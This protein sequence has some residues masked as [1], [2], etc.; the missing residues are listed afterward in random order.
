M[1]EYISSGHRIYNIYNVH[2]CS[3]MHE[4]THY[5]WRPDRALR[6]TMAEEQ[7]VKKNK[8]NEHT[9]IHMYICTYIWC[10]V[11]PPQEKGVGAGQG[12]VCVFLL[13]ILFER[14]EFLIDTS[15]K[16]SLH[17]CTRARV[18]ACS[19]SLGLS[20]WYYVPYT[21]V[22]H[23]SSAPKIRICRYVCT[24]ATSPPPPKKTES[25]AQAQRAT[26]APRTSH[27]TA[28]CV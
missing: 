18:H 23:I 17:A 9:A 26:H 25:P 5:G 10:E 7:T 20:V 21:Y 12:S 13:A 4:E 28:S 8:I 24:R 1:K 19:T 3:Y 22:S 2:I 14:S 15:P 16:K 6:L 27:C 11:M